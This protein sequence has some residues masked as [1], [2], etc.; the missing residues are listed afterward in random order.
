ML[1]TRFKRK[2]LL[3]IFACI[4]TFLSCSKGTKENVV[5]PPIKTTTLSVDSVQVVPG[6]VVVIK[7]NEKITTSEVD[8]LF[9]SST[10]KGYALGDSSYVFFV[11]V[12]APGTVSLSIPSIE[13]SNSL[14][15]TIKD[16]VSISDP[17]VIINEYVDRRNRSIDSVTKVVVG[18]NFQ[19][20]QESITVFNQM[21]EEWDLQ[22]SKLSSA[23]KN[24]LAYVLQRNMLDP[25]S[26]S[27]YCIACRLL[28]KRKW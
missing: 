4:L 11:P 5:N 10:V 19:P 13:G 22:I 17:Q 25:T 15:L 9:N 16:Y 3:F 24:L 26:Y 12:V 1:L 2:A 7:I 20:S 14:S 21:K 27:F 6:D 28:C 8:L 18:S 23:D